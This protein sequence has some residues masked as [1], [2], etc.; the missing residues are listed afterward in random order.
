[1]VKLELGDKD[2]WDQSNDLAMMFQ[3]TYQTDFYR[4]L[5]K[6]LHR[7][8][9][10]RQNL[11]QSREILNGLRHEKEELDRAWCELSQTEAHHRS[12]NPTPLKKSYDLIAAPDLS[13]R[14]N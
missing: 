9:V 5:H 14:F 12:I 1:M 4:R 2:H 8:L 13:G 10:F 3:G 6:L 11:R 7:D